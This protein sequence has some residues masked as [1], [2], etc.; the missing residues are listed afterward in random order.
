MVSKT[1]AASAKKP[2]RAH[3][4]VVANRHPNNTN[5]W[6]R[7]K[8]VAI[9][10]VSFVSI[11]GI[12]TLVLTR[13]AAITGPITGV[14]N[15]CVDNSAAR[16]ENGNKIQLWDCNG[17][18]AQAWTIAG[19][20]SLQVQGRCL[21]VPGASK[22]IGT[23]VQLW[24]CNGSAA[25]K[26][27]VSSDGSIKNPNSGFCLDDQ[28]GGTD[29]GNVLWTYSCNGTA[30]QKW[31]A[32]KANTTTP[33]PP[34]PPSQACNPLG[35]EMPVNTL[36]AS[37]K[38]VFA[39]YFPP[40]P[41]SVENEPLSEDYYPKWQYS[42]NAKDGAYDLRDRPI[43]RTPWARKDFKQADFEVE[44]RR[45]IAVGLDGFIW[46]YHTS[47]SD[48]RW[49]QL[50]AMLAAAKAVDPSFR[51]QL[52]PDFNTAA[53]ATPDSVVEDIL[54]VKD[55]PSI[56]RTDDGRIVLSPFYPERHPVSFWDSMASKLAAKGVKTAL[57]PMFLSWS[58][59]ASEKADW[60]GHVYGYSSWGTRSPSGITTLNKDAAEAHARGSIWMQ[61]VA[62]EDTRSYDGRFWEAQNST[63][64]RDSFMSAINNGSDWI[65][66]NTWNDYTESWLSPSQERGYA[67][68]DV[69]AYYISWFKTGR[70]PAV[71]QD[72]LYWFH[73]SHHTNAP[74]DK[75]PIGRNG[76]KITMAVPNGGQAT[77]DVE[78]VAFLTSPGTLTIKQGNTVKTM[79]AGAGVASFKTPLV[80]GTTPEF[81]LQRGNTVKTMASDT[82]IQ[83]KVPFQDM[84]YHAG[85]NL[86]ACK[87]P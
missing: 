4:K 30:A 33:T 84:M 55:D 62:F 56:F 36:R 64:L 54:K 49:N 35:V 61:P 41:V 20:S 14:A 6:L 44:I 42:L 27:V 25:Q 50:P 46:E 13:A 45:A 58:G 48:Q 83:T 65:T 19:D 68:M 18:A 78:L 17:T 77:N 74:F 34:T 39:F 24:D 26:W 10:I 22:E 66:L 81:S 86:T 80:A 75:Q 57:V 40:F 59:S 29:N 12:V 2:R 72:A 73:R 43:A 85:G 28:F 71:S 31:N 11:V 53:G 47:K 60:K 5:T 37:K 21:D 9:A 32:P 63:L 38:K 52:S 7:K 15:K 82:P 69:A 79:Q 16:V 67:V 87:R 1:R 8:W 23:P 51:I 70:A 76:Q 3:A